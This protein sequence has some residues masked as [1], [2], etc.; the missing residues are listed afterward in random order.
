[1]REIDDDE[2]HKSFIES[3][4]FPDR[5]KEIH[6]KAYKIAND[7]R[8]FEIDNYW[9]RA[10]YYWLFQASVYA[11][12]FYSITAENDKYLCKN[13]EIIVGVTCLGF[14]TALAW[15]FSNKG[16]KLWQENWESHVD[17]L[18]EGITGPLYKVGI[19]NK[20]WSVSKINEIVSGFSVLAWVLLGIK[21]VCSFFNCVSLIIYLA[22]LCII[23][24]PFYFYG[25]KGLG[26][27]DKEIQWYKKEEE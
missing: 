20:T 10:S 7:N 4:A 17:K 22:V 25:R 11:G 9:K 26:D 24:S 16:S 15:H 12:Y 21:T 14:L 1:M 5:A 2:Y 19:C 18:E 6:K 23:A 27:R 8:K 13:P 3:S